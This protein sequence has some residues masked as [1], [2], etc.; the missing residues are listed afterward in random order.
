MKYYNEE[1]VLLGKNISP[2]NL[3]ENLHPFTARNYYVKRT[4]MYIAELLSQIPINSLK[5]LPA[6]IGMTASLPNL[7]PTLF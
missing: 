2:Y 3:D 6:T 1:R 5:Y 4:N 7:A